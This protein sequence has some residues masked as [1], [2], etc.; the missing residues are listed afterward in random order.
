MLQYIRTQEI[1]GTYIT[2]AIFQLE[3]HQ[4]LE[5]IVERLAFRIIG[6]ATIFFSPSSSWVVPS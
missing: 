1:W 3:F 5:T 2:M 4:I 6:F